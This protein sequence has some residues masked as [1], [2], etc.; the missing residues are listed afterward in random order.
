MATELPPIIVTAD[1]GTGDQGTTSPGS[2]GIIPSTGNNPGQT[3]A[4]SLVGVPINQSAG[5]QKT[6]GQSLYYLVVI[7]SFVHGMVQAWL[8]DDIMFNVTSNWGPIVSQ[9]ADPLANWATGA[10][11]DIVTGHPISLQSQFLSNQAWRGSG[12]MTL[13]LPLHFFAETDSNLEVIEPIKRLIK[14][15]LPRRDQQTSLLIPPGPFAFSAFLDSVSNI[16][17]LKQYIGSEDT[18]DHIGVYIGNYCR[19]QEVFISH[20][21]AIKFAAKLSPEGYPMEGTVVLNVSTLMAPTAQD[22]NTIFGLS[23]GYDPEKD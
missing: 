9:I 7:K 23:H 14:M 4:G 20:L 21:S 17:N 8:P 3:P 22:I 5:V 1:P 15:A 13:Q 18:A 6:Y 10:L 2:G 19:L 12:P 11:T 16:I